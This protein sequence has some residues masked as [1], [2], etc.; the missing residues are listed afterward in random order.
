MVFYIS[1]KQW[2]KFYLIF[3]ENNCNGYEKHSYTNENSAST[4]TE[5][6]PKAQAYLDHL[7]ND[8]CNEGDS[9][10]EMELP[11][12]YNDALFRQWV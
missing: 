12:Y 9:N 4:V 7:L 10:Y 2:Y 3:L 8:G 5:E 6:N 1:S 11:P